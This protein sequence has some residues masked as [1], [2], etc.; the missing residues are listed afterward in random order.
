MSELS[1]AD[2]AKAAEL[3]ASFAGDSRKI[4]GK[5]FPKISQAG[6]TILAV[7]G[8]RFVKGF[9]KD[10]IANL[11]AGNVF[12]Y[13]LDVLQW[14]EVCAA[15]REQLRAWM[16]DPSAFKA[17]CEDL[18]LDSPLN[19]DKMTEMFYDVFDAYAE[20]REAQVQVKEDKPAKS[21]RSTPKKKARSR[22]KKRATSSG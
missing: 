16:N 19:V 10:D 11:K 17:D 14:R 6:M 1:K 8:N 4:G 21:S 7:V 13:S 9:N 20:I 5:T 15:G 22:A 18:M 2:Q 12:P 3:T